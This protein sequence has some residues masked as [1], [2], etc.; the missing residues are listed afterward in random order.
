MNDEAKRYR[1][2]VDDN[3]GGAAERMRTDVK[4]RN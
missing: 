4:K 3:E 2:L 1:M